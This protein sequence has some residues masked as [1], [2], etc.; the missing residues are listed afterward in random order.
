[1]VLVPFTEIGRTERETYFEISVVHNFRMDATER[2]SDT[3]IK[4][5]LRVERNL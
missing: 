3:I 1:M 2:L 5:V 4:Y